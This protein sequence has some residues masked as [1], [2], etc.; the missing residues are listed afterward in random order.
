MKKG[1][2]RDHKFKVR[3]CVATHAQC[4]YVLVCVCHLFI[5]VTP[6]PHTHIPI[7][8]YTYT[9]TSKQIKTKEAKT[10]DR[11]M[12]AFAE[13]G[14]IGNDDGSAAPDIVVRGMGEQRD[15][16]CRFLVVV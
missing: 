1:D 5:Y 9:H 7:L 3:P 10:Y 14:V 15:C 12:D 4:V 2:R 13:Y 16:V 8:I 11:I 6:P